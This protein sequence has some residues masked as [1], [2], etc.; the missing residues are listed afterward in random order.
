MAI[1]ENGCHNHHCRKT[2]PRTRENRGPTIRSTSNHKPEYKSYGNLSQI[3]FP[4]N[5]HKV[6]E[7]TGRFTTRNIIFEGSPAVRLTPI[8]LE[9][10]YAKK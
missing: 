4:N 7:K 5:S 6:R 1:Q 9:S 8:R 10:P 2:V 3:L